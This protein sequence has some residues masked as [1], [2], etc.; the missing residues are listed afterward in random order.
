MLPLL[1]TMEVLSLLLRILS[2]RLELADSFIISFSFNFLI[3]ALGLRAI[4]PETR[5]LDGDEP[6]PLRLESASLLLIFSSYFSLLS[7]LPIPSALL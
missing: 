7:S 5:G 2:L 6:L 1:E 3:I 4:P